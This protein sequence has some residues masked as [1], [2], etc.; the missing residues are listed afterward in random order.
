[1]YEELK[2]LLKKV[3]NSLLDIISKALHQEIDSR[4]WW[5][6]IDIWEKETDYKF[7][8][9]IYDLI[10]SIEP[11]DRIESYEY[12]QWARWH[13]RNWCTVYSAVTEMSYLMNYKY[14]DK[15]IDTIGY[16]M[17]AAGTLDPNH[18]A[19]LSDAIDAVR[20]HW[21]IT[22]P[23]RPVSSYIIDYRDAEMNRKLD[24]K[25]RMTQIGYRTSNELYAD[26]Q[27]DGMA[28]GSLYPHWWWHAVSRRKAWIV[29]NYKGKK[30]YRNTYW[31]LYLQ[32]LLKNWVVF[33]R[34]Y[35]FL[36]N[37]ETI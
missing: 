2:M 28:T 16:W 26:C 11:S 18:W 6:L 32:D 20:K 14:T 29:D 9:N 5:G 21:N 34:W 37:K 31:F 13:T 3:L 22:H 7:G 17:E 4:L 24:E 8:A 10:D 33:P 15:E 35:I 25:G 30:W 36:E 12:N 23:K 1:M 19:Y 27:D